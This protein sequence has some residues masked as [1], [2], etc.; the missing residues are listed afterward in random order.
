[1]VIL[2]GPIRH[3]LSIVDCGLGVVCVISLGWLLLVPGCGLDYL[4]ILGYLSPGCGRGL[5]PLLPGCRFVLIGW[6]A[7]WP[8][9]EV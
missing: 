5:F 4:G 3:V 6:V 9:W 8:V 7:W 2:V 1:M